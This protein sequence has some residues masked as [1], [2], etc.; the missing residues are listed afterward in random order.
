LKLPTEHLGGAKVWELIWFR[1]L[2]SETWPE[3]LGVLFQ[4]SQSAD[5]GLR[6]AAFRIFSVTPGIIEKQ[7]EEMVTSVFSK[8]FQ[9]E[10]I[11]VCPCDLAASRISNC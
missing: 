8:G 2:G 11:S 1:V 7:H 4:A 5:H 3:L 10:N 9:D 6:E